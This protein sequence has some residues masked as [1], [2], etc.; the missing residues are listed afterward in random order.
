MA[1]QAARS[2]KKSIEKEKLLL[3]ERLSL[4]IKTHRMQENKKHLCESIYK[5]RGKIFIQDTCMIFYNLE[6]YFELI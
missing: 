4:A 2:A 3:P 5:K 6:L 1:D